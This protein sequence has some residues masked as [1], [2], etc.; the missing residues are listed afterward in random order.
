M[1][2]VGRVAVVTGAAS[3]IG[4]ALAERL[5][6]EG[7]A[8]VMADVEVLPPGRLGEALDRLARGDVRFRFVVDLEAA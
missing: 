3:G 1:E 7:M 6:A 5:L 2:L 8:V 4:S